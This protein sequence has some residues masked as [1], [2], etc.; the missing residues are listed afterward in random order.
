MV[1][2]LSN[3]K[4]G[5][6]LAARFLIQVVPRGCSFLCADWGSQEY[7]FLLSAALMLLKFY[8]SDSTSHRPARMTSHLQDSVLALLQ[9]SC[10]RPSQSHPGL[11]ASKSTD[12]KDVKDISDYFCHNQKHLSSRMKLSMT[13]C[14]T[15]HSG[16][17]P[18]IFIFMNAKCLIL[19]LPCCSQ[20]FENGLGSK[21]QEG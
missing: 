13:S 10:W 4:T 12:R 20:H 11:Q 16:V 1:T 2:L 5:W 15:R 7:S 9:N 17:I 6:V 8:R 3:S 19:S 18:F 21:E 14:L